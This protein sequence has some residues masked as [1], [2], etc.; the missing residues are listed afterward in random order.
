MKWKEETTV[1]PPAWQRTI[2]MFTGKHLLE[3]SV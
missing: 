1:L 3:A 2:F